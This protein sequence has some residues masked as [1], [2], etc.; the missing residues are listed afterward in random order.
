ME[1]VDDL[2]RDGTYA[3]DVLIVAGDIS[4]DIEELKSTLA[5]LKRVFAVVFFV[6]GNH[7]L[8]VFGHHANRTPVVDTSAASG[9]SLASSEE[10]PAPAA[11]AAA[12][13]AATTGMTGGVGSAA[14]ASP[15][16][17][18]AA[19][20]PPPPPPAVLRDSVEKLAAVLAAC[21]EMGVVV[22]PARLGR[23][24][25]LPLL[26]W[27]HK[28][29]D[30]EPDIPGIPRASAMT[31]SDYARC[32]WPDLIWQQLQQQQLREEP[33]GGC[34]GNG[35]G[36]SVGHRTESWGDGGGGG[37][38][39]CEVAAW[40]DMLN[41]TRPP[42]GGRW[43]RDLG[44]R[45]GPSVPASAPVATAATASTAVGT[46]AA[47]RGSAI[48]G[49]GGRAQAVGS[50]AAGVAAAAAGASNTPPAARREGG[51]G[52]GS[53]GAGGGG[54]DDVLSFSHFLPLQELLPE[55]RYLT[56]PN[57]AKAVGST[58]LGRR[59]RRLRPHMH[60]FG[61]THFAW[62][63]EHD[64]VRY[65]QAPLAYPAERRFRLRSLVM[66]QE[67]AAAAAGAGTAA[68][69]GSGSSR[70]RG[71]EE[72]VSDDAED[73]KRAAAAAGHG[74]RKEEAPDPRG[75]QP[76]PVQGQPAV[77]EQHSGGGNGVPHPRDEQRAAEAHAQVVGSRG[78][79]G[80]EATGGLDS[81][82]P[83]GSDPGDARWLPLCVYR[84]E[85][86][87]RLRGSP[88]VAVA[89]GPGSSSS[90]ATRASSTSGVGSDAGCGGDT[91]AAVLM[92]RPLQ[93][94][95]GGS[96]VGGSSGPGSG[97]APASSGAAAQQPLAAAPAGAEVE[98]LSWR[99]Q[100]APEQA[101]MWSSYYKRSPRTPQELQLAPWV[102]ERYSRRRRRNIAKQSA[103][104]AGGDGC[105][106]EGG[107][108]GAGGR[109]CAP[110]GEAAGAAA[111]RQVGV[112]VAV[113]VA[114]VA[115]ERTG[116]SGDD[117]TGSDGGEAEV[118]ATEME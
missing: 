104:L 66:K 89:G 50:S 10:A 4:D 103:A 11:A 51:G 47:G 34:S 68:G 54:G 18:A 78:D 26:A 109:D 32:S 77:Q 20:P 72:D 117:A 63:A 45:L 38:G 67:A 90:T 13:V 75:R 56:F 58:Y 44:G 46:A 73:G 6:P 52:S 36:S 83:S 81:P 105:G 95:P 108:G 37:Q 99:S 48:G 85:Y 80:V 69:A 1:W 23:L 25:V 8:W 76:A 2:P 74:R 113:A 57:L 24:Q 21:E 61:H 86:R 12:A 84:A 35:A 14:S 88:P 71:L 42:P 59:L 31:I 60:I 28:A 82:W 114:V 116:S 19:A 70:K 64:G 22:A 100:W 40:F 49:G 43:G 33:D 29:F 97:A 5:M 79:G 101:C 106:G 65:V 7:E 107:E 115:R 102:A 87:V 110:A 111:A 98:V 15:S 62:D 9:S 27:H 16:Q 17:Q 94:A 53:G 30:T 91:P 3:N 55:K 118:L 93:A 92:L 112:G 41:D 39:S 96:G